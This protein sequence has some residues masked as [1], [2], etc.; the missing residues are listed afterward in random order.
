[1][2]FRDANRLGY[3]ILTQFVIGLLKIGRS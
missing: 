3:S 1:M 2:L